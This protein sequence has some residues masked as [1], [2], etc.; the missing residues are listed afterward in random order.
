MAKE[1]GK[2]YSAVDADE[3]EVGDLVI[4][5]NNL[6]YV[7]YNHGTDKLTGIK[8]RGEAHRFSI[9]DGFRYSLAKLIC[10]KK[11]AEVY[12]A[13][14]NGAKIEC[15]NTFKKEWQAAGDSPKFYE[16]DD[17]R[18]AQTDNK[19]DIKSIPAYCFDIVRKK[20]R[21]LVASVDTKEG[22]VILDKDFDI[23][24]INE[25][26]E[27]GNPVKC[28][29]IMPENCKECTD[30]SCTGHDCVLG[31]LQSSHEEV[32]KMT[33]TEMAKQIKHELKWCFCP[34]KSTR[35]ESR[36]KIYDLADK[37]IAEEQHRIKLHK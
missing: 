7:N 20:D 8:G 26:V 34:C 10:P 9:G 25:L 1:V 36:Q 32:K 18:I 21:T 31:C 6:A 29:R 12:K 33:V 28:D 2:I 5:G 37:I 13:W 17:Y 16:E 15:Y 23:A 30:K 4:V 14:K 35:K 3:L 22:I 27:I 11:H 24:N 19:E